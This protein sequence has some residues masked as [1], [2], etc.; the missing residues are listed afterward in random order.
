MSDRVASEV[1]WQNSCKTAR[2]PNNASIFRAEHYAVTLSLGVI[3][4]CKDK[5]FM[6]FS[7]SM[8]SLEALS[9]FKLELDLVGKILKDYT[10][11]TY[12]GRSIV[13]CWIPSHVNIP[14]SEKAY[15]GAKSAFS[16]PM[17]RVKLPT[18]DLIPRILRFCFEEWQD[19]WSNSV[20]NKL[21]LSNCTYCS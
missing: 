12:S 9:G 14:G 7:D 10:T 16:L 3:C 20:N 21:Y 17:T 2:L 5:H 13:L 18:C 19:I 15:I 6:I 4:H 8:S 1:V 11:L